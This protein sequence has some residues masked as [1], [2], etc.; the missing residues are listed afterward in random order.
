MTLS[1][2][3][4]TNDRIRGGAGQDLRIG[5]TG[6][7]SFGLTSNDFRKANTP[8]T[9]GDFEQGLDVISLGRIHAPGPT[10]GTA[11]VSATAGQLH[12]AST[13]T[14][15]TGIEGAIDGKGCADITV[16][17]TGIW[18]LPPS[19]SSCKSGRV[20]PAFDT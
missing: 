13:G 6:T 20:G 19:I 17:L 5:G 14:G 7:G 2:A 11:A 12:A 16:I 3:A 9:I 18:T 4:N 1:G 10:L 8:D 15:D